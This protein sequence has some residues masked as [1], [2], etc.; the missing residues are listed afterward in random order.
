MR[1][2]SLFVGGNETAGTEPWTHV[3]KG[4]V[5]IHSLI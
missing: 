1:E 3:G 2:P 4:K 5:F